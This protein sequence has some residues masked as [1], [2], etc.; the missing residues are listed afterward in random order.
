MER[1]EKSKRKEVMVFVDC[2]CFCRSGVV[3]ATDFLK[4]K[5]EAKI[6]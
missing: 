4:M 2:S 6:I 3:R 1:K 5:E